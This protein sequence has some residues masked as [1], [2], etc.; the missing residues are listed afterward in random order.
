MLAYGGI[1]CLLISALLTAIYMLN[2][3]VRAYFPKTEPDQEVLETATDPGWKMCVPLLLCAASVVVLGFFAE[4][5]IEF[6]R[7]V[8]LGLE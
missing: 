3:V 4:P 6:F 7:A 5:L 1:A 8:A 2:V